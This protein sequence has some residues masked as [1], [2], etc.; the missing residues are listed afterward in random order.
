MTQFCRKCLSKKAKE[1][2]VLGTVMVSVVYGADPTF[3][4]RYLPDVPVKTVDLTTTTAEY[5]PL[6]GVS[7]PDQKQLKGIPRYGELIVAPRRPPSD[8]KLAQCL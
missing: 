5:K 8:R 6:F 4:R 3:L 2:A 1:F 7:D